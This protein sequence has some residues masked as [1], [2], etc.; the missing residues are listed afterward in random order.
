MLSNPDV[1]QNMLVFVEKVQS[2]LH[3]VQTVVIMCGILGE[4][5]E[6]KKHPIPSDHGIGGL[7]Y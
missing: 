2:I 4:I 1:N 6:V 7:S 3:I 5:D